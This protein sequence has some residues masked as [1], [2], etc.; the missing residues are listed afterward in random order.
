VNTLFAESKTLRTTL[1]AFT[2]TFPKTEIEFE[3]VRFVSALRVQLEMPRPAL[4]ETE[5]APPIEKSPVVESRI[6]TKL[7]EIG[8]FATRELKRETPTEASAF[9]R[10]PALKVVVFA[11]FVLTNKFKAAPMVNGVLN[12]TEPEPPKLKPPVAEA[13]FA[14]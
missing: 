12:T 5:P 9:K 1:A 13:P 6:G 11:K 3:T 10:A 8:A 14:N 7:K 2:F 4:K